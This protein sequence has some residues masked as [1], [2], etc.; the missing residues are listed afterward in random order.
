MH[1]QLVKFEFFKHL[2]LQK[3]MQRYITYNQA[4]KR[5]SKICGKKTYQITYQMHPEEKFQQQL[6]EGEKNQ[7]QV[8]K[9]PFYPETVGNL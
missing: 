5:A 2:T 8:V 4:A 3:F 6:R 7:H 1:Q 9:N